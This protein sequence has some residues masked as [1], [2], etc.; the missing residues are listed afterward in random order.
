MSV[1]HESVPWLRLRGPGVVDHAI[2]R[3]GLAGDDRYLACGL[4]I[5]GGERIAKPERKC[6]KC[7][8]VLKEA[9]PL[10]TLP[11][12]REQRR[13]KRE[14]VSP[15]PRLPDDDDDIPPPDYGTTSNLSGGSKP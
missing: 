6:R 2:Q 3:E 14:R 8:A 1:P 13:L 7:V 15:R 5:F 10:E 4:W 12:G 9:M 11:E